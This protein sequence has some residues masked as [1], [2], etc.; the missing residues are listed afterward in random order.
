MRGPVEEGEKK[1]ETKK[2]P[3]R[4]THQ[5]LSLWDS[6]VES[7]LR[8]LDPHHRRLKLA[9]NLQRGKSRPG[10]ECVSPEGCLL[11]FPTP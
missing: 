5:L 11:S 9:S 7:F 8:V 10:G 1:L 4:R 2:E 3:P 6:F